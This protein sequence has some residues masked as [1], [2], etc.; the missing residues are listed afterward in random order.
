MSTG[1]ANGVTCGGKL[2]QLN[3]QAYIKG[4]SMVQRLLT[5]F[6]PPSM[7]SNTFDRKPNKV[8][9]ALQCAA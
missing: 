7:S 8:A 2:L 5:G 9:Q 4:L 3:H 1:M 6:S